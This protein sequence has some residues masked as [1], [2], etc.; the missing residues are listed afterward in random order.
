MADHHNPDGAPTRSLRAPAPAAAASRVRVPTWAVEVVAGPDAG[1]RVETCEALVRVGTDAGNDLVLGDDTVSR[2][3]LELER[4]PRGVLVRDLG[5]RNGTL[6]EGRSVL[7]AWLLP[8]DR[9]ALGQTRLQ[10]RLDAGE[11]ELELSGAES[12]GQLVGGSEAMRRAF[13]E[14]RR[15]ADED[16]SLLI[17][18]ETGTGKELAAR[19]VHGHSVR[20]NGPFHV[21]DCN[22]L[23]AAAERGLLGHPAP[24]P[25]APEYVGALEAAHGGTLLLDEVGEV[26]LAQQARL[27]RALEARERPGP[28]GRARPVDVRLVCTTQ[29]NLEEEVR[30][31]HF[32]E[33]LYHRLAGRRVRLPPLRARRE[34]VPLLA[35]AL[36]GARGTGRP[37]AALLRALEGHDW[38]G[39][40]RELRNVLERAPALEDA[41]DA[42][43]LLGPAGAA[44]PAPVR[45]LCKLSYH[46]AKDRV[47]AQF[48][49]HY[50]AEVMREVGFDMQR[51]EER[52]ELSMQSL[53]RLLKKNGLRIKELRSAG[54]LDK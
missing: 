18:G 2:R 4:G 48:E 13:A 7:Q 46:E 12:F 39:N 26:P 10:L 14:L 50:F 36:L 35:G 8:G 9:L 44:A 43:S 51:A 15:A 30:R 17:E 11:A 22:L 25:E 41:A 34:D 20:R 31:G 49:H 23:P 52:T 21:L 37:D 54:D 16:L 6:L 27:L 42:E 3:H 29:K 28:D 47:L 19:A 38:P 32:R 40:V 5:S 33:D 45:E 1:R 53:Y 24:A